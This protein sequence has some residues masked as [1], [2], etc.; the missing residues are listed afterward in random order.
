MTYV[1]N[2]HTAY[3]EANQRTRRMINQAIFER[4]LITDNGE[5]VGELRP[6][7]QSFAPGK[8]HRRPQRRYTQGSQ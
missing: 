1:A 2:L 8:R 6:P 7:F 5:I 3:V 4:F